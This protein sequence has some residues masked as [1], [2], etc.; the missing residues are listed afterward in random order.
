MWSGAWPTTEAVALD[1]ASGV[2]LAPMWSKWIQKS[3]VTSGSY[4]GTSV[5]VLST[6]TYTATW[7]SV[8]QTPTPAA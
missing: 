2:S 7:S 4:D 6:S 5:S 8:Y 1:P 3:V